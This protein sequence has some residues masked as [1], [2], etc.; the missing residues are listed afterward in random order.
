VARETAVGAALDDSDMHPEAFGDAA[1]LA[2]A[3]MATDILQG[4][5]ASEAGRDIH[6]VQD[7]QEIEVEGTFQLQGEEIEGESVQ[8]FR[9]EMLHHPERELQDEVGNNHHQE[10]AAFFR[11]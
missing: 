7:A 4:A 8:E 11:S 5:V 6:E 3:C 9:K 1:S 10:V 2:S